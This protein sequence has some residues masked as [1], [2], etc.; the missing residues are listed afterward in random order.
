MNPKAIKEQTGLKKDSTFNRYVK[1]TE[2][3][4]N[5]EM[6]NSWNIIGVDK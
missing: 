1:V 6:D 5:K 4:V 3:Y 2:E